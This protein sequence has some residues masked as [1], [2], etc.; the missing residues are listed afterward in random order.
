MES[1]DRKAWSILDSRPLHVNVN[2]DHMI[3]NEYTYPLD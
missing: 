2:K 3:G 1:L